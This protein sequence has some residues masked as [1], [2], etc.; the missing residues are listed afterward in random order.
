[1]QLQAIEGGPVYDMAKKGSDI[2]IGT[3]GGVY[4]SPDSGN[5]WVPKNNGIP[6]GAIKVKCILFVDSNLFAG[7]EMGGVFFSADYGNSWSPVNNG[8][9][10]MNVNALAANGNKLYAALSPQNSNPGGFFVSDNNGASWYLGNP[11]FAN[12]IAEVFADSTILCVGEYNCILKTSYDDGLTWNSHSFTTSTSGI[13]QISKYGNILMVSAGNYMYKSLDN[14]VTWSNLYYNTYG[15]IYGVAIQD[16]F[17]VFS[18]YHPA[19][20]FYRFSHDLGATWSPIINSSLVLSYQM[21][22]SVLF[23]CSMDAFKVSLDSASSWEIRNSGLFINNILK[24]HASGERI[25]ASTLSGISLSVDSGLTFTEVSNAINTYSVGCFFQYDSS[26]YFMGT[27]DFQNPVY[28]SIDSGNT[29]QSWGN[30]VLSSTGVFSMALSDTVIMAGTSDSIFINNDLTN[31]WLPANIGFNSSDVWT[32]KNYGSSTYCGTYTGIF[33]TH[34]SGASWIHQANNNFG[35][36]DYVLAL[37]IYDSVM[38]ASTRQALYSSMDFGDNWALKSATLPN[39]GWVKDIIARDSVLFL[40]IR[41]QGVFYSIDGGVT[42]VPM[43]EGLMDFR[44][45]KLTA[46]SFYLYASTEGSSIYR[47]SFD[48]IISGLPASEANFQFNIFPNPAKSEVTVQLSKQC[49]NGMISIYDLS[50]Q[51]IKNDK[52]LNSKFTTLDIENLNPGIYFIKIMDENY[53]A[54]K[55]LIKL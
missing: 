3:N 31:N 15:S 1:Q 43:N 33:V 44:V 2:F 25:L 12:Y 41:N 36:P 53:S 42:L 11:S 24:I 32:M 6:G 40:N 9:S 55:K 18:A 8:L 29:W 49:K 37:D 28:K 14:G 30:G 34:N 38:Y 51:L 48:N 52:I 13:M 21:Y 10:S 26:T 19:G 5:T 46:D 27:T 23:A 4:F 7:T 16:S 35:N 54:V 47:R 39:F 20:T 45:H 50:G 22:D 17:M